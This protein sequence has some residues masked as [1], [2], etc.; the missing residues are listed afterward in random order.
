MLES[1]G[2]AL[3]GG[4]AS[5]RIV[6][7][8]GLRLAA[9][10]ARFMKKDAFRQLVDNLR[11]DARLSSTPL[12]R[13]DGQVLEVLSGNHR[14]K[15]ARE[16]GLPWVLVMVL[17]GDMDE[18]RRIAVQLSHNALVGQDDP[19]VLAD[20]W[21]RVNDVRERLYAGLSSDALGEIAK[22]G[23]V[24]FTTP[25][26]ASKAVTFLFTEPEA[27]RLSEVLAELGRASAASAVYL[28]PLEAFDG[29]FDA[30]QAV[31]RMEKVKNAGLAMVRL[32]ELAHRALREVE[33]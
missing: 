32:V 14:I 21:S 7:P 19:A 6:D 31:K 18:G 33:Q 30:L 16:A 9:A 27:G 3:F 29:F 23:L 17:A 15:A 10:N 8:G 4:Q 2:Q 13:T 28:A 25:A 11:R 22:V 20:L 5:L 12:C 26:I 1:V 24:Q